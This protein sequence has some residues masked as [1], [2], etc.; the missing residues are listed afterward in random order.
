MSQRPAGTEG[1]GPAGVSPA[2][3]GGRGPAGAVPSPLL[4]DGDRFLVPP[5]LLFAVYLLMAGHNRP[6]G[7]FVAG[8]TMAS[9]VV[10]RAQAR[11][12]SDALR[13][14]PMAPV[15]MLAAGLL[16][17]SLVAIA[18]LLAGGDVLD[19]PFIEV[20]LPVFA[21]VKLTAA[22]IFDIGV[23]VLVVGV[24]G[25]VLEAFGDGEEAL[26]IPEG[27]QARV[28]D[29]DSP[30][31]A[32]GDEGSPFADPKTREAATGVAAEPGSG[33]NEQRST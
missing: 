15:R 6:G 19:Q 5:L 3:H 18:P 8:L 28:A 25:A 7:G 26:G 30:T 32:E 27:A 22:F 29:G 33:P 23:A 4:R 31:A 14:L 21:L 11:S 13:L 10:L 17:A 16:T 9:A 12:V 24:M 2:E 1:S 20:D